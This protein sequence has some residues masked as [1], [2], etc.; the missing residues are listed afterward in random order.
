VSPKTK[1]SL[2]LAA[3][4]ALVPVIS[5][6]FANSALT[7][8]SRAVLDD[9]APYNTV[10]NG[11]AFAAILL[12]PGFYL[13][14]PIQSA[15]FKVGYGNHFWFWLNIGEAIVSW[16]FYFGVIVLFLLW[17]ARRKSAKLNAARA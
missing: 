13:R 17:R 8:E 15:L 5:G 12:A 3:L 9:N 1:R 2:W 6:A 7:S 11:Y 16:V 14:T 4:L 10:N